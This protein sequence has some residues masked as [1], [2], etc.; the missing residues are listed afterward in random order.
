MV[1]V[2]DQL[3]HFM[4]FRYPHDNDEAP[5]NKT[6]REYIDIKDKAKLFSYEL[7]GAL[8]TTAIQVNYLTVY[9]VLNSLTVIFS[10]LE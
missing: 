9:S 1:M 8:C 5:K 2:G 7:K 3:L 6:K 4:S 10:K